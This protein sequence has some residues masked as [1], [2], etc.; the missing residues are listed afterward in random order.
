MSAF[1]ASST[2]TIILS[3]FMSAEHQDSITSVFG[4]PPKGKFMRGRH[5]VTRYILDSP[6]PSSSQKAQK[7]VCCC[8]G[9]GTNVNVYSDLAKGL[10]AQGFTVLRYD[11]LNHGW[12]KSDDPYLKVR[13][14][15]A[16]RRLLILIFL[17]TRFAR[18][19]TNN[20]LLV[21]SLLTRRSTTM[22][23][24]NRSKISLP[25]CSLT[26]DLSISLGTAPEGLC[27]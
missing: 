17:R 15:G 10:V 8:H 26:P 13:A 2:S 5:G 4:V 16:K 1:A 14:G 21:A 27:L 3:D 22:S 11:F 25:T 23:W 24:W 6:H 9:I 18:P 12:S 19:I 7:Y 20:L